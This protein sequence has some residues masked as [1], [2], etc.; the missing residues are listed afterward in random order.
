MKEPL[1]PGKILK[2]IMD[3]LFQGHVELGV[4]YLEFLYNLTDISECDL[5]MLLKCEIDINYIIAFKLGKSLGG[6][7][8]ILWLQLQKDYDDYKESKDCVLDADRIANLAVKISNEE[9][10]SFGTAHIKDA[11]KEEIKDLRIEATRVKN[12]R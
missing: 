11:G 8:M 9:F 7:S 3:D 1:H 10:I 6:T 5:E 12:E 4:S 2:I